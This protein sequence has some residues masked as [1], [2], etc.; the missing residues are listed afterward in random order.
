MSL[1]SLLGQLKEINVESGYSSGGNN[2]P[3][4]TYDGFC[5]D[6]TYTDK[7]D[8]GKFT[9]HLRTINQEPYKYYIS[10]TNKTI[11]FNMQNLMTSIYR[12]SKADLNYSGLQSNVL[13]NPTGFVTEILPHIQGKQCSF[14]LKTNRNDYQSCEINE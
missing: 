13:M 3:D 2:L 1:T 10:L 7:E 5:E 12:I 9:I 6:I 14:T 4:G 8:G 11:N